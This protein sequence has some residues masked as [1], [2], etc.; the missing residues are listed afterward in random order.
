MAL[1]EVGEN[2]K[3]NHTKNGEL[4]VEM[5][6]KLSLQSM[7]KKLPSFFCCCIHFNQIIYRKMPCA[8]SS[9]IFN[10]RMQISSKFS[11]HY[12]CVFIPSV[13]TRAVEVVR[14]KFCCKNMILM[15]KQPNNNGLPYNRES[16]SK[17]LSY[18]Y[19]QLPW[20][21]LLKQRE[22]CC[23][24][25]KRVSSFCIKYFLLGFFQFALL[26]YRWICIREYVPK[27]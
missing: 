1:K 13:M 5:R 26:L 17:V 22:L 4:P 16:Y 2:G 19:R 20:L 11:F 21:V 12:I 24:V 14:Q 3:R 9:C 18:H 25:P 23:D 10:K 27:R 8:S 15:H 6:I 7:S